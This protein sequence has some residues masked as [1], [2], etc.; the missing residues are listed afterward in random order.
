MTGLA[1][2]RMHGILHFLSPIPHPILRLSFCRSRNSAANRSDTRH[3]FA[4]WSLEING[5]ED[6]RR[7]HG[8]YVHVCDD[9]LDVARNIE[10]MTN[11][12][13]EIVEKHINF[14]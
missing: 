6:I 11:M 10:L 1:S 8:N 2:I 14:R 12:K 4:V 7:L 9:T 13:T 5:F 3:D